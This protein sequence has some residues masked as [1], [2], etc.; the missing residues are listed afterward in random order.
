MKKQSNLSRLM[1]Y[2]GNHKYFT[3]AS[4]ILSGISAVFAL[5]PF[6]YLWKIIKEVLE[7]MPDFSKATS[8]VHNGWMAVI[9]A[10]AAFLIYV[11]GLLCSH[12]AAFGFRQIC[13]K[14]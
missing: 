8:L 2:A 14:I 12:K 10:A 13:E 9:F 6:Y 3:Y 11:A 7:V 5:V 1:S 4:W